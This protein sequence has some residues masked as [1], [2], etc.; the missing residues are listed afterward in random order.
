[1]ASPRPVHP[2]V[3]FM[4]RIAVLVSILGLSLCASS[5]L[6]LNPPRTRTDAKAALQSL[7][8]TG[9]HPDLHWPQFSDFRPD[10][11]KLY[12]D[13]GWLPLWFAGERPSAAAVDLIARL[14]ACDSLGLDPA[15]YDAEWLTRTSDALALQLDKPTADEVAHFDLALSVAAVRFVSALDGGRISPSV[16][17]AQV[18][19][20]RTSREAAPEVDSLRVL[21]LQSGVLARLQPTFHHYQLLKN[22]LARYRVL[23]RDSTLATTIKFPRDLKPGM[24]LPAAATLRHRLEATGD[25]VPAPVVRKKKNAKAPADTLYTDDLVLGVKSFQRRHGLDPDGVIW[26][27]VADELNRPFAERVRQIELALERW[28]WMPASFTAPPILINLPAFRLYAFRS[29][30]DRED[31]MLAMDVLVGA[32]F[33]SETPVFAADMKYLVFRPYWEMPADIQTYEF[34]PM[35]LTDRENLERLGYVLVKSDGSDPTP[36]PLTPEN[37]KR[38]GKGLRMRQLPGENNALGLVKFM[39]PNMHDIYLHDTPVKGLFAFARRDISHGCVRV[40][41]PVALA[42]HVLR[43]QPEWTVDRIRAAMEDTTD[44]VRVDLATPIPVYMMYATASVS[45]NGDASFYADIYQLD[46]QLDALLKKGYPYPKKAP[47]GDRSEAQG[48]MSTGVPIGT[49]R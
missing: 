8:K 33:K 34:G 44:N 15:D 43:D 32:A 13:Q 35:A 49:T 22:G 23:A 9:R 10:V 39:L 38:I 31:D 24:P 19:V 29:L 11:E 1:L 28:R 2:G 48:T 21:A 41:D 4:R 14:T 37:V 42:A 3:N 46:E 27:N 45:E 40:A 20:P 6:A 12:A 30:V 7:V 18:L 36:L 17:D 25:L 5:A 47:S 16:V 26:P